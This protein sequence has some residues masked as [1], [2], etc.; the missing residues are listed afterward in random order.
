M[1]QHFA[2]LMKMPSHTLLSLTMALK[3][4]LY[5]Q[6][7]TSDTGEKDGNTLFVGP[8]M[9]LTM[10]I[11]SLILP[12]QIARLWMSSWGKWIRLQLLGSFSPPSF[13]MLSIV[14]HVDVGLF[15]LPFLLSPPPWYL[16]SKV[17]RV[18]WIYSGSKN[19]S[20]VWLFHAV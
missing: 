4:I 1:I 17:V 20:D 6:S 5:K 19:C 7:S 16:S 15:L 14:S 3:D 13:L 10:T 12:L 2:H 9:V 8:A 11:G 18:L